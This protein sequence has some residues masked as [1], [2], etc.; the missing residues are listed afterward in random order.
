MD[1]NDTHLETL[2]RLVCEAAG[3]EARTSGDFYT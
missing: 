3:C 1:N 2:R